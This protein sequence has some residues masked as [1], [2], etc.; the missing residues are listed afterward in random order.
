MP[1]QRYVATVTLKPVTDG[2]RTFW[3]WEST[4]AT[5]P[6]QRARAA[7]DGGAATSTRPASRT[8]AATCA[9]AATGAAPA[10]RAM[11]TA[12]PLPSRRA[13]VRRYGGPEHARSR[14]TA[15]RRR[16]RAGEVRI[17]QRAIG[18]NYIDVYLRRGWIPAMLPLGPAC[19]AWRRPA[20]VRRRRRRRERPA[21]RRPR[22]LPRPAARRLLQRAHRAGRLGRAPAGRGRRRRRRGDCC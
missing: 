8:C 7:R 17:R 22:R 15:R 13:V 4:F 9:T 14:T 18:V 2:D 20:R 11:P 12:L 5:P 19:R 3:H 6:G 1:L 21:A 10:A 16:P